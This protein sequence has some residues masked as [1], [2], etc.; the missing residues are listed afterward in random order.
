MQPR[1]LTL[2]ATAIALEHERRRSE[3]A[4]DV[5]DI[6][7]LLAW[8]YAGPARPERRGAARKAA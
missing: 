8:Y 6:Q 3:S 5:T 1:T 4:A 7:R 2:R